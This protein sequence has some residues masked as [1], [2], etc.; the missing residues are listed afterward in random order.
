MLGGEVVERLLCVDP[1][2]DRR[3][4]REEEIP[5]YRHQ[6]RVLL[7]DNG[8]LDPTS[9]D[10]YIALG[11]YSALARALEMG[12]EAVLEEVKR[13]GLRGRGG[14]GFPTGRKWEACR[15]ARGR[16]QVRG[17]QRRR[18]RPRR[19]HGRRAARGRPA[20]VLEGM[21]IGAYAIGAREGYVY[22]RQE[23]PL[24]VERI[25]RAIEQARELGLLGE[26][27]LGSGFASTCGSAA[28]PARSSAA[29]R[30]P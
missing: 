24:A 17:L 12:P 22:V 30:A 18:G 9:I 6:Q 25:T 16:A 23:Y 27:I 3:C 14:A 11:G 10:A 13:S 29:R 21:I 2:T 26:H 7:R 15:K 28:A 8:L 5:F 19:V 1:A 4:T 20:R